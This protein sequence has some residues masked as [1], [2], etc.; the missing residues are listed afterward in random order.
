MRRIPARAYVALS[1]MTLLVTS[2]M[3]LS[4]LVGLS[5]CKDRSAS[6]NAS[7]ANSQVE[8][9]QGS[10]DSEKL[11]AYSDALLKIAN[12]DLLAAGLAAAEQSGVRTCMHLSA[13]QARLEAVAEM[14]HDVA[15]RTSLN[16]DQG[17]NS[18]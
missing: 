6:S 11:V 1:G 18:Y 15:Y 16:L 5:G 2:T 12:R 10:V 9:S 14:Q 3:G 7:A 4:T 17:L 13:A 8:A